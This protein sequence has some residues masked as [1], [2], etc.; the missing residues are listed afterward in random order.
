MGT[1][2]VVQSA[3][4]MCD[5]AG[6]GQ[7]PTRLSSRVKISGEAVVLTP[8]QYT[9][10]GCPLTSGP[11]NTPCATMTFST[12]STRVTVEGS[13]PLLQNGTALAVGPLPVQGQ[14]RVLT[15]QPRVTA[16]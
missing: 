4:T 8:A 7:N 2:I 9:V 1:P 16:L 6:Q 11:S 10:A 3:P 14:G 5:H 15:T 13:P 12:G